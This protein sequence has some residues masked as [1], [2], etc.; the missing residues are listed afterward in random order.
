M[1]AENPEAEI[2]VSHD[3]GEV[4]A[5]QIYLPIIIFKVSAVYLLILKSLRNNRNLSLPF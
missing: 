4:T 3:L 5:D 2:L 1:K